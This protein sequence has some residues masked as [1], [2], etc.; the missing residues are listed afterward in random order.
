MCGLD[1]WIYTKVHGWFLE[2]KEDER[3]TNYLILTF[4]ICYKMDFL[5]FVLDGINHTSHNY[6]D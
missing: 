4:G 5:P 1:I 6:Y 2:I 3:H